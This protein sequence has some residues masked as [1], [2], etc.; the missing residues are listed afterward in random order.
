MSQPAGAAGHEAV[1][2]RGA[3]GS[4]WFMRDDS[5]KPVKLD[6][7][8]T[9]QINQLTA[10]LYLQKRFTYP[11]PPT[12]IAV[13]DAKYPPIQPDGVIHHVATP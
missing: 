7:A 8:T 11:L 3:D 2:F 12:V 9:D 13:L 6:Q 10:N 4:L 1:L 5:N